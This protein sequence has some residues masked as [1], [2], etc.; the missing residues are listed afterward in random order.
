[1]IKETRG[2]KCNLDKFD[3]VFFEDLPENSTLTE[4]EKKQLLRYR[5]IFHSILQFPW[6]T[7]TKLVEE[8][9]LLI[10]PFWN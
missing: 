1:M 5:Y 7:K 6:R 2:R 4:V 10:T 3:Q 8:V 9:M